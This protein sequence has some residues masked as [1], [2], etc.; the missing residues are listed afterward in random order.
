MLINIPSGEVVWNDAT[1]SNG[2]ACYIEQY[3][4]R[5]YAR[6]SHISVDFLGYVND[7][8]QSQSIVINILAAYKY[9]AFINISF[10]ATERCFA[11]S[12]FLAQK[13]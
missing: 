13:T 2:C 6:N 11:T 12:N 4:A 5:L 8:L 3:I 7:I 10:C 9:D 1:S